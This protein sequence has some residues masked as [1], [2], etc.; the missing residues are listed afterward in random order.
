[1]VNQHKHLLKPGDQYIGGGCNQLDFVSN[2]SILDRESY[3]FGQPK[4]AILKKPH[5]SVGFLKVTALMLQKC[6]SRIK[7]IH[8]VM[9]STG[10]ISTSYK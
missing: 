6:V 8:R 3:D 9:N 1:M 10:L 5:P 7:L 2:R 4:I